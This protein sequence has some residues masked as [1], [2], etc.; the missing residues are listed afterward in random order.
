MALGAKWDPDARRWYVARGTDPGKFARCR[1]VRSTT[2]LRVPV[3][4]W[5]EAMTLGALW[6]SD[7]WLWYVER[8]LDLARFSKWPVEEAPCRQ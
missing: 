4:D 2:Y 6:D 7:V 3:S 5:L 1:P 8:G